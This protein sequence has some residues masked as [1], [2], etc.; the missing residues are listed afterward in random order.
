MLTN[1]TLL[2]KGKRGIVYIADYQGKKIAIKTLN[3]ESKAIN[4]IENEANFLKKL[5]K[6]KIDPKFLF[7]E[8]NELG[9][10]FI[11][12]E[13]FQKYIQKSDKKAILKVIKE[14]FRQLYQMDKLGIN[15]EEMHHPFKHIIIRN[16]RPILIDFERCR[17]TERPKNVTQF[18][19]YLIGKNISEIISKKGIKIEEENITKQLMIYKNDFSR[20]SLN[21]LLSFFS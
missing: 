18:M 11:E 14:L 8:N 13:L 1:R 6:F 21:N 20:K 15:K 17:Y 9:M 7:F 2:A 10:E 19:Q 12:G 16:N 3:P 5:N 4:R